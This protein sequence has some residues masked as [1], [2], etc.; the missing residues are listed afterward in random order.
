MKITKEQW[1][2]IF[3]VSILLLTL[4]LVGVTFYE[5]WKYDQSTKI[6]EN[7]ITEGVVQK[8]NFDR[9][10]KELK[11]EN[12]ELYDSLKQYKDQIDFLTQF[13]YN[14]KYKTD[15]VWAT[16]TVFKTPEEKIVYIEKMK[17]DTTVKTYR[18]ANDKND[19]INYKLEVGSRTE[20]VWY[21]VDV[22]VSDKF[23]IVNKKENGVNFTE[24][25]SENK[26]EI[27]NVTAFNK[28]EKR[29]WNKIAIGP[30]IT[31]GYDF[32]SK[33]F[34]PTVGISVTYNLFGK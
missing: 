15:T 14:K 4:I 17:S 2:K 20:P 29:I 19:S 32:N 24:I 27:T 31:Y 30:S 16:K 18:Y 3:W 6:I 25:K 7:E 22:S 5:N 26:G 28:K 8:A 33:K 11:K 12:K 9:D 21:T 13:N 23:T 10:F 1:S 34:A